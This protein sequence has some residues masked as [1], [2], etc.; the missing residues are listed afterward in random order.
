[1]FEEGDIGVL[2]WD[3]GRGRGGERYDGE[4]GGE[5]EIK[6]GG[7]EVEGVEI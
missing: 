1:M 7:V 6:F 2:G 4:I 5:G 3:G